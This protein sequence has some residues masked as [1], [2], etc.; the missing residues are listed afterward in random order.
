MIFGH[1]AVSIR[2]QLLSLSITS[3][4]GALL[5][6]NGVE[7][8]APTKQQIAFFPIEMGISKST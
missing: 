2:F 6:T 7:A 5:L 8:E 4:V 1:R 3:A